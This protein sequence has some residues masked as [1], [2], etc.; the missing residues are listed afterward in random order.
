MAN[1]LKIKSRQSG[2]AGAPGEL[3]RAELAYNE[4]DNTLY[5]GHGSGTDS[6]RTKKAIGGVG[7]FVDLASTQTLTNKNLTA[8]SNTFPNL[9]TFTVGGN[10]AMGNNKITGLGTPTTANDAVNKSYVDA[11]QTGLDVKGSV[12]VATTGDLGGSWPNLGSSVTIDGVTLSTGDRVLVKDQSTASENGIYRYE[13]SGSVDDFIRATDADNSPAGEVTSGMFTF[14]EDGST[15]A[16]SGFVLSTTGSI[17]L[18]STSLA[19]SQF[20]GAGQITAGN[21]LQKAGDTLS[22]DLKANAGLEINGGEIQVDLTH[23]G[24]GAQGDLAVADGGTGA[25]SVSGARSNLGLT[26][27]GDVQAYDADLNTIA[28]F[29]HTTS[30]GSNAYGILES[31]GSTWTKTHSP[32]NLTIDCGT[33]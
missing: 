1:V 13:Q 17:T 31:D 19:F 33:Y 32:S 26:I 23:A 16:N 27:G 11:V 15:H 2:A 20:S 25:S 28:G 6:S 12:R 24:I 10:V 3:A 14:V 21:G 29:T 4:Q 9:E 18:G 30:A 5:I 22:V 8:S 7:G